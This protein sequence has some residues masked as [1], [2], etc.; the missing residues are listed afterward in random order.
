MALKMKGETVANKLA[1][2]EKLEGADRVE[3]IR[4][5]AR[6]PMYGLLSEE[7]AC[8]VYD[9]LVA[10][11]YVKRRV[12]EDGLAVEEVGLVTGV[13]E[14]SPPAVHAYDIL[15]AAGQHMQ[16]RASQRDL[17]DGE[18]SMRRCVEAFNALTGHNLDE[19]EGWMFMAV[20]KAARSCANP[21]KPNRDDFEDGAAYFGLAG[22]AALREG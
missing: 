1:E 14:K 6:V 4:S 3:S 19:R 17:P 18:R 22:E 21:H 20:L 7:Q 15:T 11:G 16:D 10:H 8:R 12:S 13:A 2:I 5:A 9:V